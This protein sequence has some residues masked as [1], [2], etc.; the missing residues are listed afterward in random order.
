[1]S[2]TKGTEAQ[3]SQTILKSYGGLVPWER[4]PAGSQ[5]ASCELLQMA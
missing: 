4:V 5:P 3:R 2:R 1:M